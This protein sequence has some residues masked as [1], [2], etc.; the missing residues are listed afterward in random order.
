M[1]SNGIPE[2]SSSSLI[3][4][5][6]TRYVF[7]VGGIVICLWIE[8]CRLVILVKLELFCVLQSECLC[9]RVPSLANVGL[10]RLP[11]TCK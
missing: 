11:L 10:F 2:S 6:D 8:V 5:G 9:N 1:I 3:G 7:Y 4:K